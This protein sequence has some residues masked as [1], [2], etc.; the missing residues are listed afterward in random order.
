VAVACGGGGGCAFVAAG[1]VGCRC[2]RASP[3]SG[4][5]G[6]RCFHVS[7]ISGHVVLAVVFLVAALAVLILRLRAL[8]VS[9]RVVPV[10]VFLAATAILAAAALVDVGVLVVGPVLILVLV[11]VLVVIPVVIFVLVLT[12]VLVLILV[13]LVVLCLC[14]LLLALTVAA[15]PLCSSLLSLLHWSSSSELAS[16]FLLWSLALSLLLESLWS[17]CFLLLALGVALDQEVLSNTSE[18]RWRPIGARVGWVVVFV[19]SAHG[20]GATA[21]PLISRT[22]SALIYSRKISKKKH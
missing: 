1:C 2:F 21:S 6:C 17:G 19:E 8:P 22:S 4:H 3:I 5:V 18:C 11:F 10:I 13:V 9:S 12:V 15:V 16:L 20:R 7:P 14:F